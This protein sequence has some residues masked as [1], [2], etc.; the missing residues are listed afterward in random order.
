MSMTLRQQRLIAMGDTEVLA[1]VFAN[2]ASPPSAHVLHLMGNGEK[3]QC[4][5]ALGLVGGLAMGMD[6]DDWPV[7][8]DGLMGLV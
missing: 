1:M 8:A 6:E 7:L 2:A 3:I 5:E 4:D